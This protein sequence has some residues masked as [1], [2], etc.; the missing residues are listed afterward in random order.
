MKVLVLFPLQDRV[1]VER[2]TTDLA[3]S[4]SPL[5]TPDNAKEKPILGKVIRVGRGK[6]LEDGRI[7]PIAVNPG[8]TVLF[9]KYGGTDVDLGPGREFL[10]LREDEIIA[11]VE[12]KEEDEDGGP[13]EGPNAG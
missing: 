12:E 2:L 3:S 6:M 11:L 9:A 5:E 10:V 4:Y 8:D 7:I 13:V 1:V